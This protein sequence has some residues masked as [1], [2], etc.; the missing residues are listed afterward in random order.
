LHVF[1]R[2]P[3]FEGVFQLGIEAV[4]SRKN[5]V[6]FALGFFVEPLLIGW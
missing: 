6:D 5:L 3:V 1:D 4:P 2:V